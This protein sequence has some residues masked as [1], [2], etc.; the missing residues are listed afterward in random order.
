[1]RCFF[2]VVLFLLIIF[3]VKGF[4]EFGFNEKVVEIIIGVDVI[5]YCGVILVICC[6]VEG[7]DDVM[8]YWISW[9]KVVVVGKVVKI[10]NDLVI[11]DI[12]GWYVLLYICIVRMSRG[13]DNVELIV[14]VKG[15]WNWMMFLVLFY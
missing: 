1:M 8:V 12:D 6:F 14:Y 4:F 13:R 11:S 5:V 7:V 3:K 2:F 15:V 9:G 10:G